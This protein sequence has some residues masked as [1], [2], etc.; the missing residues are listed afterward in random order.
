MDITYN[1]RK[2]MVDEYGHLVTHAIVE[3]YVAYRARVYKDVFMWTCNITSPTTD[4]NVMWIRNETNT[5]DLRIHA[6]YAKAPS[7]CDLELWLGVGNTAGGTAIEGRNTYAGQ[8]KDEGADCRYQ[9]TNVDA[10]A[11]MEIFSNEQIGVAGELSLDV[12]GIVTLPYQREFAVNL[13]GA[14]AN[15][16]INLLGFFDPPV[17]L[18]A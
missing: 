18:P 13:I 2:A 1:S 3:K 6:L 7:A 11:G 10:G 16:K 9:N 17:T 8:P 5:K 14:P 4:D 15:I 12:E